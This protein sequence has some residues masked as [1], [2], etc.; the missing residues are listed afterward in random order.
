MK[1]LLMAGSFAALAWYVA[2]R[3]RLLKTRDGS[4]HRELP[5]GERASDSTPVTMFGVNIDALPLSDVL[6]SIERTVDTKGH[7]I[8]TYVN[9][10]GMNLAYTLP[11]FRV[12]LNRCE[13]VFCDGYGVILGAKLLGYSIP[14]RYTPPDWIGELVERAAKRNYSLFLIGS[15]PGVADKAA[16]Q[17][18]SQ[19]PYIRIAGTH[20]GYANKRP[21]HPENE[22]VLQKINAA[23]P[24]IL[25]VGFGMPLQEQWLDNNW[26]RIDAH[27]ALT[28]GALF[29][30]MT[31]EVWRAPRWITDNKL[32]WLARLVVE[33]RRLWKRY[34]LGNPL[35]LLR[36]LEERFLATRPPD[37][38]SR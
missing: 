9:A 21:G 26:Q 33:P 22:A 10:H 36:I 3:G 20:H 29:D 34:V 8:V 5:V 1:R 38:P 18:K 25:V 15:M 31:G 30:Y 4:S 14:E 32:E 13:I 16:Q 2:A 35:F 11:W 7:S 24:D 37:V 12:F 6:A 27:V 17:L 19:F 23:K 28:V